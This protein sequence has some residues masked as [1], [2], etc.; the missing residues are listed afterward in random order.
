[1]EKKQAIDFLSQHQPLPDDGEALDVLIE[2]FN[3]IRKYFM[4]FPDPSCIPLFLNC[5]G[6]G[7]GYGVYQ[8]IEY[9]IIKFDDSIVLPHLKRSLYSNFSSVRYWC[10]QIAANYDSEDL[11]E[12]LINVYEKGDDDSKCAALTALSEIPHQKTYELARKVI[13][14]ETD[15]LLLEIANDIMDNLS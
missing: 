10:S 12:G 8:L 15:D 11:L 6:N 2:E 9:L 5:F 3:E 14:D 1:M 13:D 7:D 4:E